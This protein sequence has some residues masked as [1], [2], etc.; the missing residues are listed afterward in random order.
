MKKLMYFLLL[1]TVM[2]VLPFNVFAEGEDSGEDAKT[3]ETEKSDEVLVYF[4]RGDGCPHCQEAE[5]W[6]ESLDKDMKSKFDIVDLETWENTNNASIMTKVAE[7]RGE[8]ETATGV[9]YIIIGDK[10]WVGFAEDMTSE[11]ES[12]INTVY[13]Q[14]VEE[15][16]D[17]WDTAGITEERNIIDNDADEEEESSNDVVSLIIV[18]V[19]VAGVCFGVYKARQTV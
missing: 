19:V 11:I 13:K 12:Q 6:F 17:V 5:E 15:R 2:L 16:Y 1:F 7:T 9:P 4:F 10:S 14:A 18:L 3:E 8:S